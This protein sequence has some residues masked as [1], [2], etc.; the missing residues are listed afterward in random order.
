[1][2]LSN[3]LCKTAYEPNCLPDRNVMS[4]VCDKVCQTLHLHQLSQRCRSGRG[5]AGGRG[6]VAPPPPM[7]ILGGKHIV[8]PPPPQ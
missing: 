5:R 2:K 4:E 3:A 7:I 8:L 6:A 1:M